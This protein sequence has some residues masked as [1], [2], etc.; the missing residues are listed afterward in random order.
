[1]SNIKKKLSKY[2]P[3][4]V[5]QFLVHKGNEH[6]VK[7][8]P[9]IIKA[10]GADIMQF[11]SMQVYSRTGVEELIPDTGKYNRY[12]MANKKKQPKNQKFMFQNMVTGG[13][14]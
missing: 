10:L 6:Q 8:A 3:L 14:Q 11:K 12:H 9:K 1:L 5:I 7:A 2:N 4:I 13:L